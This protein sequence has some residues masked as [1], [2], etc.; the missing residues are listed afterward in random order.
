MQ[1]RILSVVPAVDPKT[2]ELPDG[3]DLDAVCEALRRAGARF[4]YLHG[5]RAS[6][7]HRPDSDLDVA[8]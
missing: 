5:S 7:S 6:G 2:V 4:A 8:A 1:V 3:V